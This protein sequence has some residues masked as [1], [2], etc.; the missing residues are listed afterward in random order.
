MFGENEILVSKTDL[1][2][3]ITYANAAFLRVAGFSE[4]E[5]LG[6]PHNMIRHPDMPRAVFRLMWETI[7]AR[8]EI[9]A[10]VKNLCRDG[11][12]YWVF[13]HVTPSL[14]ATGAVTGYHSFRRW[15]RRDAIA[16]VDSLYARM[17]A[18]ESERGGPRDGMAASG[19]LLTQLLEQKGCT[20]DAFILSL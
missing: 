2:G 9:F 14:D 19:A 16:A 4:E 13:A 12:H 17:V 11:D 3:Q 5:M 15:A 1:K 6:R 8:Q 20:Y 18:T 7:Q 10:Y